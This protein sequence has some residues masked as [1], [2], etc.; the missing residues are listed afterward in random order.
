MNRRGGTEINLPPEKHTSFD[1]DDVKTDSWCLG[2]VLYS[3][4]QQGKHPFTIYGQCVSETAEF[5]VPFP[6]SDQAAARPLAQLC[7][8]ILDRDVGR[9]PTVQA[10]RE[11]LFAGFSPSHVVDNAE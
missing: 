4:L 8:K 10:I 5:V 6:G 3:M 1:S 2:L 11:D 7:S 9:R